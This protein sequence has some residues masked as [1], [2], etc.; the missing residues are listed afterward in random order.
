M[1]QERIIRR[2][3]RIFETGFQDRGKWQNI[4]LRL[5]S[6]LPFTTV[7]YGSNNGIDLLNWVLLCV[8]ESIVMFRVR[9]SFVFIF[10]Y[11]YKFSS[12]LNIKNNEFSYIHTNLYM[13][14]WSH[15]HTPTY[16]LYDVLYHKYL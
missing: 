14:S 15:T 7:K 5:E 16:N 6:Y 2:H 3:G 11:L 12:K 9:K 8:T 1:S 4:L 13:I 10:K